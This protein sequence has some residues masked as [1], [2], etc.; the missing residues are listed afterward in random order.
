MGKAT[1]RLKLWNEQDG[2]CPLCNEEILKS[3]PTKGDLHFRTG[4]LKKS[5]DPLAH[6]GWL[7]GKHDK[8]VHG[9][10]GQPFNAWKGT[11]VYYDFIPEFRRLEGLAE[12][13]R[14]D[15]FKMWIAYKQALAYRS[16]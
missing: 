16:N 14:I 4:E 5:F 15:L 6:D 13:E 7:L 2:I 11:K 9:K 1:I 12:G 3:E 10:C 8:L